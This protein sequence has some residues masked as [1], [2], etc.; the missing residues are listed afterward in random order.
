[1]CEFILLLFFEYL[2]PNM[3]LKCL[4]EPSMAAFMFKN[5]DKTKETFKT[6]TYLCTFQHG[7]YI[8]I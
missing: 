7:V 4:L 6:T 5:M 2:K 3:D 1:M 8:R